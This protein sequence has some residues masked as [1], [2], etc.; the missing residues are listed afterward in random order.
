[1]SKSL[2]QPA[3]EDLAGETLLRLP[4]IIGDS[5]RGI[6]AIIPLSRSTFLKMVKDGRAP[7][8][9]RFGQRNTC[10][11][12]S[13]IRTWIQDLPTSGSITMDFGGVKQD[14]AA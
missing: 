14:E 2:P 6:P 10:W 1:M 13:S 5:A 12:L 4:Q 8:P 9:I 7:Q 11:R 3:N